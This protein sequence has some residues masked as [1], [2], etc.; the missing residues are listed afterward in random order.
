MHLEK[1]TGAVVLLRLLLSESSKA[2]GECSKDK[3]YKS[4]LRD[5]HYF[6]LLFYF[7]LA[8]DVIRRNRVDIVKQVKP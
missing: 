3:V 1:I 6:H 4:N 8:R 2:F 7:M 5:S